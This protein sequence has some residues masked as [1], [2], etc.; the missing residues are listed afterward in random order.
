MKFKEK[1]FQEKATRQV[2]EHLYNSPEYLELRC[3]LIGEG[4]KVVDYE[5]NACLFIGWRD[6][7]NPVCP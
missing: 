7:V 1:L 6:C 2:V 3:T 5:K 4:F